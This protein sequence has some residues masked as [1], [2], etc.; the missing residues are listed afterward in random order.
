MD[1]FGIFT[2]NLL[3]VFLVAG[4]GWALASTLR[5]DPRALAQ[6]GLHVLA[7]CL[8]LEVILQSRVPAADLARMLGFALVCLALPA[9]L[10]WA[11]ARWR[12]WPRT[13]VSAVV[14]AVL[15]T[16]SGNYGLSVSVLAF[17]QRGLAQAS[18]FFLASMIL[19][20]TAGVFVASMGRTGVKDSAAGLLRMPAVW[21]MVVAFTMTGI[22]A[23]LPGPVA[24]AVH[25]L[26][27]ACIPVFLL[28]LGMQL[29]GARLAGSLRPVAL[30]T[31]IRLAGGVAA[32]LL[33]APVFGLSGA[34]RQA[35][36]LQ[37]AMP[38]AVIATVLASEYD[39]EPAF[40]TSVILLGTLLSPFTL[41]PL[42]A[43]LR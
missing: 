17:G 28:V 34:A 6:V 27:Q 33:L 22:G 19:S 38:T 39:V 25:L 13:R 10:A 41:T 37:S 36:V 8:I 43:W 20:Y 40:V 35:G 42:L 29:R 18:L 3:P 24:S 11:V 23:R 2:Q 14:L 31:V 9:A 4:V 21:A 16:N 12:G 32:G 7:P 26:S 5:P 30:A 15:L 1:M